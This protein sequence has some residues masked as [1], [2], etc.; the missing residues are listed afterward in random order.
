MTS[1]AMPNLPRHKAERRNRWLRT[2]RML[3][4]ICHVRLHFSTALPERARKTLPKKCICWEG[5]GVLEKLLVGWRG[6]WGPRGVK[7]G[8]VDS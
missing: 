2:P 4:R 5:N 3:E 1:L 6:Q 8:L 7:V